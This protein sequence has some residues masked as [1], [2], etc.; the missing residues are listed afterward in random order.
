MADE[1]TYKL[2]PAG[3]DEYSYALLPDDKPSANGGVN[4]TRRVGANV[5]AGAAAGVA[6]MISAPSYRDLLRSG[7]VGKELGLG[8]I[9][10]TKTPIPAPVIPGVG[11]V[12]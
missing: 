2:L 9:I 11:L 3:D 4:Q 7:A 1:Y 5:L 12:P 6:D 8:D 10:G